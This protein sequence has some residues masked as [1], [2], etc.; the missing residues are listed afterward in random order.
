MYIQVLELRI[1]ANFDYTYIK[2]FSDNCAVK[3]VPGHKEVL[4]LRSPGVRV[5]EP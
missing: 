2:D 3:L 5:L 1:T 4:K